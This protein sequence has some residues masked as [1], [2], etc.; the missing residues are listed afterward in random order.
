MSH[1][2]KD[3]FKHQKGS[4]MKRTT[5]KEKKQSRCSVT[6]GCQKEREREAEKLKQSRLNLSEREKKL[7]K[8]EDLRRMVS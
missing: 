8:S 6:K 3:F 1:S 7:V 4:L 2:Q 5:G